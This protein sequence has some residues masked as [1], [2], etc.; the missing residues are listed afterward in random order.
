MLTLCDRLGCEVNKE[1]QFRLV[2]FIIG[3]YN[4]SREAIA[5]VKITSVS[6]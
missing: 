6:H 1:A 5:E 3:L 4:G 2:A